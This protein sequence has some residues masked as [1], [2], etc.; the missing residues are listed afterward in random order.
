MFQEER[1]QFMESGNKIKTQQPFIMQPEDSDFAP[2]RAGFNK[3]EQVFGFGRKHGQNQSSEN[4]SPSRR[5]S[6]S[7]FTIVSKSLRLGK[8]VYSEKNNFRTYK[9]APNAQLTDL[10][11]EFY[12]NKLNHL[13]RNGINKPN[14]LKKRVGQDSKNEDMIP[15]DGRSNSIIDKIKRDIKPGNGMTREFSMKHWNGPS[16][17]EFVESQIRNNEARQSGLA[18][19]LSSVVNSGQGL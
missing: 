3:T 6:S 7:P 16:M 11:R 8:A 13:Q 17:D 2:R 18:S 9:K 4:S 15:L 5:T 10:Y 1:M 14:K 19:L 12:H